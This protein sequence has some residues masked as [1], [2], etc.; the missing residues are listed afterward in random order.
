MYLEYWGLDR[1]PFDD[2]A[3]ERFFFRSREIDTVAE[4][5]HEAVVRRRGLAVLIGEIGC[6]KT[7]VCQHVLL[8]LP[9]TRYRIVWIT[10]ARLGPGEMLVEIGTQLGLEISG[11]DRN[12]MLEQLRRHM[13]DNVRSD[14]DTV[15]CI[16]EAQTI[17]ANETFEELRLLLNFQLANRFLVTLLFIGQPEL[18]RMIAQL[19]QLQQR[20]AL[21]L[22]LGRYSQEESTR[23]LLFRL[24]SAGCSRPILTRQAATAVHRYTLGVPRRMNHLMDRCLALGARRGA[25]LIDRKLVEAT[26]QLYPC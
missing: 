17:P 13:V 11:R 24:R 8:Q 6:G 21:N 18:Q 26:A 10:N 22:H 5:L 4:D 25:R 3:D 9:E 2:V 15:V 12:A 20:V 7:T 23:Y 14:R 19:P 16:D 1:F